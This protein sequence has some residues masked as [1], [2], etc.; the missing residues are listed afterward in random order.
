MLAAVMH[1]IDMHI[2]MIQWVLNK[3]IVHVML[4]RG[5]IDFA[6]EDTESDRVCALNRITAIV[7]APNALL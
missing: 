2:L 5:L 1:G 4:L 6:S 7:H 3:G